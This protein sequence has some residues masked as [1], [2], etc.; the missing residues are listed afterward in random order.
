MLSGR[1]EFNPDRVVFNLLTSK[2]VI[3]FKMFGL[4]MKDRIVAKFN[5]TLIVTKEVGRLVIQ[6][7][8][9]F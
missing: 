8:E 6:K 1:N 3:N 2:M 4:L 9:L 5:A 7:F